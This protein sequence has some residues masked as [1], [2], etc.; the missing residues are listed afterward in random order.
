MIWEL[1]MDLHD[2]EDRFCNAVGFVMTR[3][4]TLVVQSQEL[5]RLLYGSQI[6]NS[7]DFER[8]NTLSYLV[9][10]PTKVIPVSHR[11]CSTSDAVPFRLSD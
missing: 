10:K 8:N 3:Y 9:R 6:L 1:D 5:M 4:P 2:Y 11:V 7:S